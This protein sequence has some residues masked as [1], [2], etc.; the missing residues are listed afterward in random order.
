MAQ[1][2]VPTTASQ[3]MH[4]TPT[5][6]AMPARTTEAP[7]MIYDEELSFAMLK[8]FTDA[9]AQQRCL[10]E[11]LKDETIRTIQAEFN[12]NSKNKTDVKERA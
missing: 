7:I 4:P 6:N 5:M 12:L 10:I 3:S 11:K 8:E 1:T 2:Q 9:I